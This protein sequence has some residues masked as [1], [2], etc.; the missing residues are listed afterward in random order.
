MNLKACFDPPIGLNVELNYL[1]QVLLLV[2]ST[3]VGMVVDVQIM[4][5]F[6]S[7]FVRGETQRH[8]WHSGGW[9]RSTCCSCTIYFVTYYIY[10]TYRYTVP[11]LFFIYWC[12]LCRVCVNDSRIFPWII[13]CKSHIHINRYVMICRMSRMYELLHPYVD[14]III[15]KLLQCGHSPP[16]RSCSTCNS[17]ILSLWNVGP[18]VTVTQKNA[19]GLTFSRQ[20]AQ[21]SWYFF[22][23]ASFKALF[24]WCATLSKGFF[25]SELRR[26]KFR[27]NLGTL[28]TVTDGLLFYSSLATYTAYV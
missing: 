15:S 28:W 17:K 4:H 16:F 18:D 23:L 22:Q 14:T 1:P 12:L 3:G 25:L 24:F 11:L 7:T 21:L 2:E 26:L 27:M 6:I 9:I 5:W 8:L 10:L 19:K 20:T 13:I